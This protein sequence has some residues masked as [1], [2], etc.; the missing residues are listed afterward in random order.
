MKKKKRKKIIHKLV[1]DIKYKNG[2][3][4]LNYPIDHIL[5]QIFKIIS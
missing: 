2:K 4:N 3:K 5:H 1:L